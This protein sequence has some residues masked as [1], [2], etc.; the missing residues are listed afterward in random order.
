MII[1]SDRTWPSGLLVQGG[2]DTSAAGRS[3]ELKS[4]KVEW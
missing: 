4:A 2:G 3:A 1:R